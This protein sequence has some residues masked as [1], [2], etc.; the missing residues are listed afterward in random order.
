MDIVIVAYKL[1]YSVCVYIKQLFIDHFDVLFHLLLAFVY[2]V[3]LWDLIATS[4]N[5][6]LLRGVLS[7]PQS[8]NGLLVESLVVPRRVSKHSS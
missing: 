3:A 6:P 8:L 2:S 5:T 4:S 1:F 7:F